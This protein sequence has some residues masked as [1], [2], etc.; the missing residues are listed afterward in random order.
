LRE[1]GLTA[2][3]ELAE[4]RGVAAALDTVEKLKPE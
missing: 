2:A 1:V 3:A 4:K